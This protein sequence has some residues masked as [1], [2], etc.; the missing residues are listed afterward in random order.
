VGSDFDYSPQLE[1]LLRQGN[2]DAPKQ[3]RIM[4]LNPSHPILAKMQD[5]FAKD[6]DAAI[7]GDYAELLLGYGLIAEGSELHDPVKFTHLVGTLMEQG[8]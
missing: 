1:R 7:L 8:L 4:E 2:L 6:K 5:Q 3:K